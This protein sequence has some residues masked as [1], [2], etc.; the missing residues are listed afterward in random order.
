MPNQVSLTLKAHREIRCPVCA[1]SILNETAAVYRGVLVC[2]ACR[3]RP[4]EAALDNAVLPI[5][6]GKRQVHCAISK[7]VILWCPQPWRDKRVSA[8]ANDPSYR[9]AY[10]IQ[11]DQ[12]E[13]G[14]LSAPRAGWL[15]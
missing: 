12:T 15:K 1:D 4:D 10:D 8:Q 3:T 11:N 2:C 6:A 13:T 7:C 9:L 5:L 14:S